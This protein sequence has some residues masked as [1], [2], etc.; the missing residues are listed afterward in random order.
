MC[1]VLVPSDDIAST[2]SPT[3]TASSTTPGSPVTVTVTPTVT[4]SVL[5]TIVG[6][7]NVNVVGNVLWISLF[8]I[9]MGVWFQ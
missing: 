8:A 6:A 9:G 1:S 7:A 5:P 4:Q 3:Y 2:G